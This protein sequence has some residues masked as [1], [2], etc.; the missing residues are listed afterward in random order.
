MIR[1]LT[2]IKHVLSNV[3]YVENPW[4]ILDAYLLVFLEVEKPF[5]NIYLI[6]ALN[7]KEFWG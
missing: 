7:F 6:L 5:E 4:E 3:R 1:M 2:I